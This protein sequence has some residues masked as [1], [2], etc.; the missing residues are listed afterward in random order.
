[1]NNQA[2]YTAIN[3][4]ATGSATQVKPS[5]NRIHGLDTLRASA[6]IF[7]YLYHLGFVAHK[8]VF[9]IGWIGVDLFF[10]LSG[11]LIGNQIFT[12]IAH[13]RNF[14]FKTFMM[15]RLLRTLPNY[16]VVLAIYIFVDG[17]REQP[18]LPSLWALFTFTANFGLKI[19]TAF[20]QV[21]SLCIEEQFYLALPIIAI[22]IY[23]KKSIRLA[24][25]LV[26]LA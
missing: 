16:F 20:S 10:V 26:A 25:Y 22:F 6:I 11:Y 3:I 15:R 18:I 23:Y 9:D 1:M 21:W 8:S 13:K 17:F 14:V 24:W 2:Q 7:V 4:R 12:D 19:G 5:I